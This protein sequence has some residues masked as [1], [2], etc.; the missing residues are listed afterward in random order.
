MPEPRYDFLLAVLRRRT[1][2]GYELVGVSVIYNPQI[3]QNNSFRREYVRDKYLLSGVEREMCSEHK[4]PVNSIEFER[5]GAPMGAV[6]L[7][8]VVP[9]LGVHSVVVKK[10]FG[11]YNL[12]GHMHFLLTREFIHKNRLEKWLE[13][14]CAELHKLGGGKYLITST[15]TPE[16][17]RFAL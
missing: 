6:I 8:G 3:P 11:H 13:G 5:E 4:L 12:D 7:W 2:I 17:P 10:I 1:L 15:Q 16:V 14:M 9:M